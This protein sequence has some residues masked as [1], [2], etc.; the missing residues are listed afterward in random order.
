MKILFTLLP[1][2]LATITVATAQNEHPVVSLNHYVTFLNRSVDILIGRFEMLQTYHSDLAQFKKRPDM[3]L[4][5]PSSGP[6]EDFYYKRALLAAGLK[7]SEKQQLN[8]RAKA[9]WELLS[10]LDETAKAL[11]TYVR[12]QTYQ[13]DSLRQ[14]EV[15]VSDMLMTFNRF[16]H[17]KAAFYELIRKI[18]RKYSPE[19]TS[20]VFLLTEKNMEE[21]LQS[22]QQLLD[23]LPYYLDETTR[24]SW[25]KELVKESL[26]RDQQLLATIHLTAEKL[27]YPASSA[28]LNFRAAL[29]NMQT[30]KKRAVNGYNSTAALSSRHGNE[31]YLSLLQLYNQDLAATYQLFAEFASPHRHLLYQPA[32]SPVVHLAPPP[33]IVP[34]TGQTPTFTDIPYENF[35]AKKSAS[36]AG[37]TTVAVLNQYVEFI[38]E[39]LRQMHI[40][41]ITLRNYQSSAEP[42]R[43]A[44]YARQ[45][46]ALSF[47][48]QDFTIPSADYTLLISASS[49]I[50]QPYRT[51]IASQAEVLMN[52]L[53]EMEGLAAELIAYTSGKHYQE[54][55]LHKSDAILGRYIQLFEIFDERKERLYND[56]RRIHASYNN[57]APRSS[58]TIAGNALLQVLD[59]DRTALF[60]VKDFMQGKT[61]TPPATADLE[62]GGKKLLADEY[63]HMKGLQRYG[64]SNGLCPYSPY[65]DLA[66]NSIRF[67]EKVRSARLPAG[68]YG[69]HPYESFFYFYNNELIYE[70][71]KFVDLSKTGLLKAVHQPDLFVFQLNNPK[72]QR[73]AAKP[74]GTEQSQT[75][76]SA[77][78]PTSTPQTYKSIAPAVTTGRDKRD[79]IYIERV[80][81][82]TVYV[83]HPAAQEPVRTLD[84]FAPNNMVLL[85][86]VSSSMNSPAKLPLLKRSIKSL[87]TLLRTED[88]ISIVIYSGRARLVLK[89]TSGSKASDI[90]R[91]IDRLQSD[92][93]TDAD[94][95]LKLAYKTAGRQYIRGGNN[96][97]ILATDGEFPVSDEVMQMI[98][99]QA[100]QDISLSVFAFGKNQRDFQKLKKLSKAG[101]GNYAHITDA[102]ADLQLILEAQSKK[103]LSK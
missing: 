95:G 3:L 87:L 58:W 29:R 57:M 23:S 2:L 96:R 28:L 103:M 86:D 25:P 17:E 67:A 71:N 40:M 50:Q 51:A 7:P 44:T 15:Y 92:G 68:S 18:Y 80:R 19:T 79:T 6:P 42:Y 64:R 83:F 9:L 66:E 56:L 55:Q 70:Y 53:R 26:L 90:S 97:I 94:E 12:L 47:S 77:T 84:G 32:Y 60:G 24:S 76:S 48:P 37:P 74:A 41:Q 10:H 62:A 63:I 16:S 22:Q 36:P 78:P 93:D 5:L 99:S 65:E 54:D 102:S 21:V 39:S 49:S 38:N 73:L 52:I 88:Y 27:G 8:A 31:M 100:Q 101:N 69:A 85:L 75:S 61:A 82:D 20:N 81:T 59:D 35:T 30:S 89:P 34:V 72:N 91:M 13:S 11:E 43:S 14:S 46:A 45:R 98:E 4:R 33:A 1:V